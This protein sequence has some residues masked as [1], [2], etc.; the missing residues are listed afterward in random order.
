[1]T[2]F[3]ADLEADRMPAPQCTMGAILATLDADDPA[4][5]A[6]VRSAL[7]GNYTGAAIGRQLRKRGFRIED[8]TLQRHRRQVCQC[9]Q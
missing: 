1:V 9:A 7:A 5:A 6:Q 3:I 4:L 2:D 8:S